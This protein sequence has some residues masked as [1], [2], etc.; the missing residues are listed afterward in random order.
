VHIHGN[1][2]SGFAESSIVKIKNKKIPNVCEITFINNALA[3]NKII[4]SR[5]LPSIGD[6]PNAPQRKDILLNYW[7]K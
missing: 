4:M 6:Y 5:D 1:N 2:W 3:K 7:K